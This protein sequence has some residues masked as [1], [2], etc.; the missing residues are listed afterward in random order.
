MTALAVAL[1][2]TP[3]TLTAKVGDTHKYKSTATLVLPDGKSKG[4]ITM[5]VTERVSAVSPEGKITVVVT[6]ANLVL[7]IDTQDTPTGPVTKQTVPTEKATSTTEIHAADGT[8]VSFMG[9]SVKPEST[10]LTYLE[11]IQFPKTPIAK[12]AAWTWAIPADASIGL[13]K[14]QVDF[15]VL[16]DEKVDGVDCWKISRTAKEL[17][18]DS[19]ASLDGTAWV[20]K[21]DGSLVKRLDNWKN[22][23]ASQGLFKDASTTKE[24]QPAG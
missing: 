19:P 5:D 21:T 7:E 15:K 12:D 4:Q 2:G 17:E 11:S 10:R 18:G 8:L 24:L 3:L 6:P 9:A 1:D 20:S 13:L 16:G 23:P 14:S 22:M